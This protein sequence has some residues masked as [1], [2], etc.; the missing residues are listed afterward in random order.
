MYNAI[1]KRIK[2]LAPNLEKN[3]EF[4]MSD[5]E[6]AAMS[7]MNE[8]FPQSKIHGCWFHFNQVYLIFFLLNVALTIHL[9]KLK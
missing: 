4:I 3:L 6:V 2:E 9:L 7:S 5:Y 8:N 1:W